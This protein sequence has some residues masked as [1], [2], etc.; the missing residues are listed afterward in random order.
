MAKASFI[1]K[2]DG[3]LETN[4]YGTQSF[5]QYVAKVNMTFLLI[6]TLMWFFFFF[7]FSMHSEQCGKHF[8]VGL[9]VL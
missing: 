8:H 7:F 6:L 4:D 9:N 5:R 3:S 1:H 2:K